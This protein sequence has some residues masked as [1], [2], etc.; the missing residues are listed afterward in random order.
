M[1]LEEDEDKEVANLKERLRRNFTGVCY[2]KKKQYK[3]RMLKFDWRDEDAEVL[4]VED[5]KRGER[6]S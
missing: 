4:I 5:D 2:Y 1:S 6:I 3:M